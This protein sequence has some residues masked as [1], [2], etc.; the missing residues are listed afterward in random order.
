METQDPLIIAR[1]GNRLVLS[2]NNENSQPSVVLEAPN[3]S[4][5]LV[6]IEKVPLSAA[7]E[8]YPNDVYAVIGVINLL[9]GPYLVIWFHI[10]ILNIFRLWQQKLKRL[11]ILKRVKCFELIRV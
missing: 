3:N 1:F 9:A 8:V 7:D 2:I 6:H 11:E 10:E 5:F 4:Q